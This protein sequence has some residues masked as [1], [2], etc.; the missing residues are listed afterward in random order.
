M[1][2][3]YKL[4][5]DSNYFRK[6]VDR[7][8]QQKPFLLHLHVQFGLLAALPLL[9]LAYAFITRAP[10]T[11]GAL[12]SAVLLVAVCAGSAYL[13][14]ALILKRLLKSKDFGLDTTIT[15]SVEGLTTFNSRVQSKIEWSAYPRSVRYPDGILL[16]RARAIRWLPD[17]ALLD[18]SPELATSLVQ[19]K[20]DFRR[21][22]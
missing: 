18:S 1:D 20:T 10:W 13:T 5:P 19:S 8:Y 4:K 12:V 21:I 14:K 2:I 15:I 6:V 22:A 7:Y 9:V 16:L 3:T 17:S 11:S